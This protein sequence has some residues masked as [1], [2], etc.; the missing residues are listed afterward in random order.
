MAYDQSITRTETG[1]GTGSLIPDAERN[2]ILKGVQASSIALQLGRRVNLSTKVERQPV[3]SALP[4]AYW[5]DGDTG[6]KDTTKAEWDSKLLTAEE[7]AVIVPVPDAVRD[8]AAYDIFAEIRPLL[9]EAIAVKLDAA[10]LFGTDAP[11]SYEDSI[12]EGALA[13]GN[14][15]TKGTNSPDLAEDINQVMAHVEAD[16]FMVNGFAARTRLKAQFRGLRDQN[17]NLLFSP[18]LTAGTP[19]SLYGENVV[20]GADALGNWIDEGV[21]LIAGDWSKLVVGVRQDITFKLFT[22]GVISDSSGNVVLNLMQ[23]DSKALRVVARYAYTIANP[24][25]SSG[26]TRFPFFALET[27]E[28]S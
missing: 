11:T 20:F 1:T 24:I 6:L 3:L 5:V 17:D 27:T 10:V 28:G 19:S 9:V 14:V 23:Q 25:A 7:L 8:D 26:V 2:E 4:E 12:V 16:G 15:E 18:S 13:A 21:D 22:E